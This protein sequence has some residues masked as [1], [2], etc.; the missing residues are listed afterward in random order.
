[1]ILTICSGNYVL[2]VI[3]SLR[4]ITIQIYFQASGYEMEVRK[5]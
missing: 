5:Q 4:E 1:M 3:I 2:W